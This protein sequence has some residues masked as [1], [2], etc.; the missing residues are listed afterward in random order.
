MSKRKVGISIVVLVIILWAIAALGELAFDCQ[1]ALGSGVHCAKGGVLG[2]FIESYAEMFEVGI[3]FF[4]FAVVPLGFVFGI[5]ILIW[6][7]FKKTSK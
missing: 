7:F 5:G 3:I 1:G 6:N 4:I 2:S